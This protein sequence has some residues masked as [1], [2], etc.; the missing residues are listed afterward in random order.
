M[1]TLMPFLWPKKS[2]GLQFRVVFCIGLLIAGRCINVL[3]PIYNQKIGKHL[4]IYS[5]VNRQI[6]T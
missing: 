1:R 5:E 2:A 4:D 6:L 3:V